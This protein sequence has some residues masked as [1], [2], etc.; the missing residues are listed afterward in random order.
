MIRTFP[1]TLSPIMFSPLSLISSI[2]SPQHLPHTHL[3][4]V[5][6][7]TMVTHYILSTGRSGRCSTLFYCCVS[8][9]TL[10]YCCVSDST[11]FY[12]CVMDSTLFYCSVVDSTL[13]YCSVVDST[14]FYCCVSDSTLF[15]CC[16]M[17]STLLPCVVGCVV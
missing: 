9:S 11:L 5:I 17:D 10:F 14:L 3:Q 6:Q 7:H 15:Y 1:L 8:D 2:C 13:F 12:C 4:I 16:V